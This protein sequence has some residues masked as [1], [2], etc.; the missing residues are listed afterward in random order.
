M[1]EWP[2]ARKAGLRARVSREPFHVVAA[3]G[4]TLCGIDLCDNPGGAWIFSV[5]FTTCHMCDKCRKA[6]ALTLGATLR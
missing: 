4:R 6:L 2:C 1:A 3:E 5:R